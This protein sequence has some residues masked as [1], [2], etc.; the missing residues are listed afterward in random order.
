[1]RTIAIALLALAIAPLTAGAFVGSLSSTDMGILGTGNWIITGPTTLS[2][3]VHFDYD[4]NNWL[5][6]YDFSHPVGATSH[7][8]LEVSPTFTANDIL[9]SSG[10]FGSADVDDYS[11]GGGNPN[12]PGSI[13]GIKFD[14]T[15][16][17]TTHLEFR[18][19][20][21]PVWGDFYAKD[22]NA[23]GYGVNTA[24]N[25]G[26]TASDTDPLAPARDGSLENHILVPDTIEQ[27]PDVPEPT[28][29][30]LLGP[31]LLGVVGFL[32]KRR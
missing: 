13:Y 6:S 1:M 7:F 23:G 4:A 20:R 3:S 22:G 21:A 16:G 30:L 19:L 24:W 26:F 29:L 31:G 2:W 17:E 15:T 32:R 5:Y 8:I 28:T 10:D 27:I 25:A 14:E 18:T 11:A 12:M 9:W